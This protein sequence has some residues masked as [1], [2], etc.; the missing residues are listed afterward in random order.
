MRLAFGSI[1]FHDHTSYIV[2][3]Y[4]SM[5]DKM[6]KKR[7]FDNFTQQQ[8]FVKLFLNIIPDLKWRKE[9]FNKGLSYASRNDVSF[10]FYVA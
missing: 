3:D 8:V 6:L 7:V 9:Q 1:C 5:F 10:I 4:P 2:K